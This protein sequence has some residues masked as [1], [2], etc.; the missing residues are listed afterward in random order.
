MKGERENEPF[1]FLSLFVRFSIHN[2]YTQSGSV[3]GERKQIAQTKQ[4][5]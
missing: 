2:T 3:N 4:V 5:N 1:Q